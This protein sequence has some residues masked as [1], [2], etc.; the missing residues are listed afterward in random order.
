VSQQLALNDWKYQPGAPKRGEAYFEMPIQMNFVGEFMN[1]YSFLTEVEHLQRLT[2]IRKVAIKSKDFKRG[3]VEVEI[4][5]NI[6]Y[7]E[8]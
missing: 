3:I 8:G 5:L 6:Y 4:G 1:V 2:R 7:S